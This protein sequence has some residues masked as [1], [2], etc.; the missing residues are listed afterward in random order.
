[1]KRREFTTV[2]GAAAVGWPLAANAQQPTMPVIGYLGSGSPDQAAHLV[3]GFRQG[4]KETGFA[5]GQNVAIE[6]R[7]AEGRY[8]RLAAMANDLVRAQVAVILADGPPAALAAKAATAAIPIIFT[9]GEDPVKLGL[10]TSFTWVAP[11]NGSSVGRTLSVIESY[12]TSPPT[13]QSGG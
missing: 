11:W 3:A 6:Y 13:S 7:W 1:M 5:E 12:S 10:V 2:L 9:S 4:L 8:D